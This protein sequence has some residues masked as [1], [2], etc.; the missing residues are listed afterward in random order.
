[1]SRRILIID[2]DKSLSESIATRCRAMGLEAET[3][4][5]PLTA[6]TIANERPVDI[7]CLDVEMPAGNGLS[8]GEFFA[9][10][11]STA[12]K[13][14]IILTGRKDESTKQR[15]GELQARYVHK[16]PNY[17]EPLQAA[18]TELLDISPKSSPAAANA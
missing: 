18:I 12:N 9:T 13:P 14:I 2:D 15:C 16:S 4:A 11:P 7:I 8:V 10:D 1:M 6:I 3:A 5:N 17:W